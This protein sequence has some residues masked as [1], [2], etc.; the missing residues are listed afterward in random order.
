MLWLYLFLFLSILYI[1]VIVASITGLPFSHFRGYDCICCV[2]WD[3]CIFAFW[4]RRSA[5]ENAFSCLC[6]AQLEWDSPEW[7]FEC[8]RWSLQWWQ[9]TA[10]SFIADIIVV[11][12]V[13]FT[14]GKSMERRK[15]PFFL[16][17]SGFFSYKRVKVNKS[18]F[19]MESHMS[20]RIQFL[21]P[22]MPVITSPRL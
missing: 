19:E 3:P 14:V 18:N 21:W 8:I 12:K 22:S 6:T 9:T 11:V 5:A 13:A 7:R 1:I 17:D 16:V 4:Y 2:F 15:S 10:F 20:A